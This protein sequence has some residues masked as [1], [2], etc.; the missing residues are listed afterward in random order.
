[1]RLDPW[2]RVL[3]VIYCLEAGVFLTLTPW[4]FSWDRSWLSVPF[5]LLRNLFLHPA[6]RGAV[7]GFGVVH[8]IWAAYDLTAWIDGLRRPAGGSR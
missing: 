7:S 3:F 2:L 8:L 6:A 5:P 4:A 1:M